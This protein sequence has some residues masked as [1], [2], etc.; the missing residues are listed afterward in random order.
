MFHMFIIIFPILHPCFPPPQPPTPNAPGARVL[1]VLRGAP[2]PVHRGAQGAET[3]RVGRRD[4]QQRHVGA[5]Q[6]T[7]EEERQVA[8]VDGTWCRGVKVG[9][10]DLYHDCSYCDALEW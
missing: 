9:G 2:R 1:R 3:V 7:A 6:A 8:Q 4:V 5:H 10:G